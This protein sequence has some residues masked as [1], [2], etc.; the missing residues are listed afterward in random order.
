[1][2]GRPRFR[3]RAHSVKFVMTAIHERDDR[4]L[5]SEH[6]PGADHVFPITLENVANRGFVHGE[7]CALGAM[8]VAWKVGQ[9]DELAN[10]LEQ[11]LVRHR[12]G[13]MGLTRD[14][15]AAA[16]K[17]LPADLEAREVNSVLAREPISGSEFDELWEYLSER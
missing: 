4:M 15:L 14:E 6:A 17:A 1:M 2:I 11:A 13:Q 10:W 7:L 3:S 9:P 16:V 12:P 5:R 8:I